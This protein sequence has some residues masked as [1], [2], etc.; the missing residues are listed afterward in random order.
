MGGEVFRVVATWLATYAIHSTL[1]LAGA[2]IVARCW[3]RAPA[4]R[5]EILWRGALVG[6]VITATVHCVA[7]APVWN[8]PIGI[9]SRG[10]ASVPRPALPAPVLE[11]RPALVPAGAPATEATAVPG[12]AASTPDRLAG[13]EGTFPGDPMAWIPAI[14]LLGVAWV[15]ARRRAGRSRL[16]RLLAERRALADASM[17]DRLARLRAEAGFRRRVRLTVVEGLSSP[18]ALGVVRPEICLPVRARA[19]L[20]PS[21]Q[22]AMLAHELAHLVRRDPLWLG[23]A[24]GLTALFFFQPLNLLACARLR[25]NA[26]ILCDAWAARR[27]DRRE[28]L[29]ECLARVA[30]WIVARPAPA[31]ALTMARRLSLLGTRIDRLLA[32]TPREERRSPLG[33]RLAALAPVVLVG[34]LAPGFGG[35]LPEAA[36]RSPDRPVVEAIDPF[37]ALDAELAL[38]EAESAELLLLLRGADLPEAAARIES[39]LQALR[40]RRT[41]LRSLTPESGR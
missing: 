19:E 30:D 39:R 1:L 26:E 24:R 40:E 27:S 16:R 20:T 36:A 22:E 23:L 6:G 7:G 32:E 17:H 8:A 9:Q 10:A 38:L 5:L 41:R 14:W 18:V 11:P 15:V 34:A 4:R 29:A 35:G 3:R 28:A 13:H 2:W 21:Q 31:A 12:A 25:D 33:W 37:A